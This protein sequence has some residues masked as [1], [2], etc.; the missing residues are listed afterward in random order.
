M[1]LHRRRYLR[2]VGAAA[3]GLTAGC[4]DVVSTGDAPRP[5]LDRDAPP[6]TVDRDAWPAP[7]ADARNSG[8]TSAPGPGNAPGLAWRRSLDGGP[9]VRSPPVARDGDLFVRDGGTLSC[10]DPGDGS[11]RWR[12]SGDAL[13][14]GGAPTVAE[15]AVFVPG[16]RRVH[17]YDRRGRRRWRSDR[18]PGTPQAVTVRDDS[19]FVAV[20][21]EDPSVVCLS[22]ADGTR[23]WQ[24]E[25]ADVFGPPAVAPARVVV[26]DAGGDVTCLDPADGRVRWRR[27]TGHGGV[28][29]APVV[30][31]ARAYV[32]T[33]GDDAETGGAVLAYDLR[34]GRREWARTSDVVAVGAAPAGGDGSLFVV[35]SRG[36]LRRLD[37]V[38]GEVT[39][40]FSAL[41][42]AGS[43]PVEV[44]APAVS[45]GLV[46]CAAADRGLRVVE[47]DAG[48][49]GRPVAARFRADVRATSP[50]T[51]AG[52]ALFVGTR[53]GLLAVGRVP[54]EG[55]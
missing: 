14:P 30:D 31:R 40:R 2:A 1:S 35:D 21:G 29:A 15:D 52:D 47:T 25:T 49:G 20:A 37:A 26:A 10:L 28:R 51:V 8:V 55:V 9:P 6:P 43:D 42:A 3:V 41:R 18:L 53:R 27:S 50:P 4:A 22:A 36:T 11:L 39:W 19:L 44:F 32:G 16:G 5:M 54:A 17:A 48:E 46:Y 12:V 24:Y 38:D 23:R 13:G 7:R 33:T 34:A 45:N